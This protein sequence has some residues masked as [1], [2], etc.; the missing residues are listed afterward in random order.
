M[1]NNL[2]QILAFIVE[3][4]K[5][6]RVSR[7][8][9]PVG[10]ER[11]ENSAE[12]SW[13]VALVALLLAD[14]ADQE[15]DVQRVVKMMLIHDI[16]EIDC[17]DVFVYDTQARDAIQECEQKAAKRIFGMLPQGRG[18]EFLGL[19]EEFEAGDTPE[20]QYAKAVDRI[21][22]A[23]QNINSE[24]S[25]WQ[26]HGITLEQVLENNSK[27]RGISE[28]VWQHMRGKIEKSELWE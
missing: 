19:W 11:H 8:T 20:A 18:E 12:H 16:V 10:L 13:H 2:E 9:K 21:V 23:L 24:G 22:P 27:I 28:R 15:I 26:T 5:L 6:K 1:T 17:G 25:S 14:E 3:I 7:M 4:D